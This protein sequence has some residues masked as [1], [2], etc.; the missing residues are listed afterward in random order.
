MDRVRFPHYQNGWGVVSTAR[1]VPRVPS[2]WNSSDT[3]VEVEGG[4]GDSSFC[5]AARLPLNAD[6]PDRVGLAK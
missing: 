5:S 2:C 3:Q 4:R 1:F 6:R